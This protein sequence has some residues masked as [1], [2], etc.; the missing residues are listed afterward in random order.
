M[1]ELKDIKKGYK[2]GD[3]YQQVLKGIDIIFRRNEFTSILGSSGSGK[4][5]LLNIIGGLDNYDNGDLLIDGV[6]TKEYKDKDWD[7]YRNYRVGFIFQS[8]NLIMH[9]SVLSNVEI[10]LTLSGISKKQRKERAIDALIK[11]GL[12]DQ[13]YKKPNQLSGG[14]MQRVAIA[15]ALVN[16]PEI[17]LADEPTGALDSKTSFQIMDLLKEI[18][19]DK[20]VIMVTHNPE[21]AKT[22]STRIIELKDGLIINDSNPFN[23]K[24]E[25]KPN[26][27]K[28]SR[29]SMSL[30]SA[31]SLSFNNLL[32][33]K[34]R[35]FLTALAGSIGIIGI[36][37]I[38]SLSNGVNKYAR[39]LEKES[40]ADYPLTFERVNYDLF[41]AL[42][43]AFNSVEDEEKCDDGKICSRDDIV[44]ESII[45]SD[46]GLVQKN[47]LKEFNSKNF[48]K[49]K[50]IIIKLKIKMIIIN[51][52]PW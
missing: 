48:Q 17:I 30:S 4:T 22:Y 24:K 3:N 37:L 43:T 20:L 49:I 23:G 41:G 31:L 7:S 50:W 2:V 51:I 46:K 40:L 47:N 5:T 13:I 38:I 25:E 8:Y 18:A 10:A 39:N 19:S 15:R 32:T 34:G 26:V 9:Q 45:S 16:N 36:S 6:S 52:Y 21:I 29:T 33:K 1:L 27:R 42:T 28:I 12:E 14:Q 44:K 35:T 11:V